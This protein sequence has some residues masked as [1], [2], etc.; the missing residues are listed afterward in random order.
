MDA[1][2]G[3]ELWLQSFLPSELDTGD[4]STSLTGRFYLRERIPAEWAAEP[5]WAFWKRE[6]I[7]LSPPVF[8]HPTVQLVAWPLYRIRYPEPAMFFFFY[9]ILASW[10]F[11]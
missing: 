5:V 9:I 8:E 1:Y 3:A 2:R 7:I 6:N 4:R 10:S 11:Q